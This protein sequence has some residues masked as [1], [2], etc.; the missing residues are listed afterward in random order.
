[1]SEKK[2]G[3]DPARLDAKQLAALLVKAGGRTIT[4]ARPDQ[5]QS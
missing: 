5:G 3:I 1:M 2:A 4:E